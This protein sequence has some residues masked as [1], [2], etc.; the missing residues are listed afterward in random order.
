[1]KKEEWGQKMRKTHAAK[2]K[3]AA[4]C[5]KEK[6]G[7]MSA[8]LRSLWQTMQRQ[9][10]KKPFRDTLLHI[11]AATGWWMKHNKGLDKGGTFAQQ[12]TQNRPVT[13]TQSWTSAFCNVIPCFS[14]WCSERYQ[15]S[16]LR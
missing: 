13:L 2:S 5:R 10:A 4:Q 3:A 11:L 15:L 12:K 8:S 14:P 1:M 16:S 9:E 7:R 6:H